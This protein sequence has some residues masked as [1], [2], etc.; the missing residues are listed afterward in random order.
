MPVTVRRSIEILGLCALLFLLFQGRGTIMPLLMA[1][2]IAIVLMPLYR[3]FRRIRI[4]ESLSIILCIVVMALV[5]VG[6]VA[7]L[8]FQVSLLVR[9]IPTIQ[10][11]VGL[12]LQ[13]L[14][15]W[16][17]EKMHYSTQQQLD[18]LNKQAQQVSGNVGA[19]LS[20]AATSLSSVFIFIGLL[21]IYIFLMMFYKNTLLRF[22]FMWFPQSTH[23]RVAS[24]LR[25][26]QDI[27]KYYI[28]GL[29]IQITYL[30]VLVGGVLLLMGIKHAILIGIIFAILN[31]IPYLGALVGNI[32]AVLLTLT[33]SQELWQIVAVLGVIAGVQF[34]DNNILMPRIVGG[35]VKINA[36]MSII[37][38]FVGGAL[39]GISGMF[40]S[41][42]IMAVLKI[43]FDKTDGMRQWGVLLGEDRP[44]MS[45]MNYPAAR[46][47][48]RITNTN[49]TDSS[50]KSA[51]P[52]SL[53]DT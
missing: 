19:Y 53:S 43:I 15:N 40:L 35:K 39:A 49:P 17:N 7:F 36:L 18:I 20:G 47:T 12:H 41:L 4:P 33:G 23:D 31:L 11:N 25:E 22:T 21:P 26:M 42:P 46:L 14:S 51:D 52:S 34:L 32:I 24:A 48:N 13:S 8:S 3:F 38:I 50:D 44:T 16:V 2:F 5:V 30:T 9:D 27:L 6:I 37:G 28:L 10:Q 29:L 45:P 1:F